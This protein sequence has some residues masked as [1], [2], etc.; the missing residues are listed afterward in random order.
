M[1]EMTR[2]RDRSDSVVPLFFCLHR[3]TWQQSRLLH[4]GSLDSPIR[5]GRIGRVDFA[6]AGRPAFQ[7]DRRRD[8]PATRRASKR[9]RTPSGS[10]LRW[11]VLRRACIHNGNCKVRSASISSHGV[12]M[13]FWT[14]LAALLATGLVLFWR[15]R[16]FPAGCCQICGYDLTANASGTC[17]ECGQQI[18]KGIAYAPS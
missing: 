1:V 17:P 4:E 3:D 12:R 8:L 14:L 10:G 6:G 16:R 9:L 13:P 11:L 2:R 15:D 18:P 5:G 7:T